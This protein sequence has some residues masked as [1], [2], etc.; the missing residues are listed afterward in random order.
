MFRLR[1]ARSALHAD[2]RSSTVTAPTAQRTTLADALEHVRAEPLLWTRTAAL[3]DDNGMW[4]VRLL[5]LVSGPIAPPS[6]EPQTWEYPR[7]AFIAQALG[8]PVVAEQL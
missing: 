5:E 6:W 8:G 2:A 7:V 3:L 1:R 4:T